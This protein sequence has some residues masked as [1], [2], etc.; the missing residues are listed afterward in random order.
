[1]IKN[2]FLKTFL[3]CGRPVSGGRSSQ[4]R[5]LVWSV[6][7]LLAVSLSFAKNCLPALLDTYRRRPVAMGTRGLAPIKV[8]LLALCRL[9]LPA[10]LCNVFI[11]YFLNEGRLAEEIRRLGIRVDLIDENTTPFFKM[12]LALRKIVAE[13]CLHVIHSHNYKENILAYLVSKLIGGLKLVGT[14]HGMLPMPGGKTSIRSNWIARSNLF[15]LSR[16]FHRIVAV[17][18]TIQRTFVEECGFDEGKIRVIHNGIEIPSNRPKKKHEETFVIGSSGRLF[19][20]KDYPFMAEIATAIIKKENHIL[21]QLA[22][23]GPERAKLQALIKEYGL[24]DVFMLKGHLE[25]IS[26]F[27]RELDLYLNTS[28]YEGIP[29]SILEAMAY[30]LPVV[31]PKVGGLREIVDEGV[32]G[33][34]LEERDPQEFAEKC[35]FLY[36]KKALRQKMSQAAREKVLR[37]FSLEKMVKN[38]FNIYVELFMKD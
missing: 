2:I 8:G 9:E 33:Y 26:A 14:Q 20:V 1:M 35:I 37:E 29:M 6:C 25:D 4:G 28:I 36:K 15:V 22:G 23:D 5:S 17:S 30:G 11:A 34:L 31:A 13:R 38:Y 7:L 32:Q 16:C 12:L 27:Y 10:D 18:E 19:P 24:N 3:L 21:F